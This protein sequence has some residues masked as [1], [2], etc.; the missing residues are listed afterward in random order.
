[1]PVV[2]P[3]L[4]GVGSRAGE[5]TPSRTTHLVD[6]P[7]SANCPTDDYSDRAIVF[8][9]VL[10]GRIG[11]SRRVVHVFELASQVTPEGT[12]SACCGEELDLGD[13]Q[14]LPAMLGM[15]CEFCVLNSLV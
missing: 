10:P 8:G 7:G 3:V 13:L 14:W 9:R 4:D 2:R 11:E 1:M 6:R 15:P 12:L 5:M